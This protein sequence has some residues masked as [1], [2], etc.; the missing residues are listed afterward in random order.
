MVI[1]LLNHWLNNDFHWTI[2]DFILMGSMIYGTGFVSITLINIVKN[3]IL[4]WII[5]GL[6][7]LLFL[8]VWA[9][10]AVGIF[11]APFGGS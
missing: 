8:L 3:N 4:R 10:F 6:L 9:D 2:G 7:I 1:P 5:N 11:H